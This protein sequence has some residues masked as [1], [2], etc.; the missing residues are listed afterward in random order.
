MDLKG[1][2]EEYGK[3]CDE[4]GIDSTKDVEAACAISALMKGRKQ[5]LVKLGRLIKGR[6]AIVFGAGP[7][8]EDG[9]ANL[10]SPKKGQVMIAADGATSA[11]LKFGLRPDV[12]VTDLDGDMDDI[13][14]ADREGAI[15]VVHAHGD[16]MEKLRKWVPRLKNVVATT[17]AAPLK[18]VRDFFGFTDGDRAVFLATRFK[19]KG[20]MLIGF[21]FGK[22]VGGYSKPERPYNHR[23]SQIKERKLAIAKRLIG[24]VAES[25]RD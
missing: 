8:L 22:V 14:R 11:L 19:A 12:V 20:V 15:I 3:I 17:Q 7:S 18:N 5:P 10:G 2:L 24:A 1:W 13:A 16:N 9:L 25:A 23:A 21:D 4:L 6:D